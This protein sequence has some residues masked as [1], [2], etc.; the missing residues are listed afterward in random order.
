MNWKIFSILVAVL[1]FCLLITF[2]EIRGTSTGLK[3]LIPF[4]I[5]TNIVLVFLANAN[6]LEKISK[7][8]KIK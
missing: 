4:L 8:K 2:L 1:V 6:L 3:Y 7:Q 5:I